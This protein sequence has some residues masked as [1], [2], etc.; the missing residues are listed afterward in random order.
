MP[1]E[2]VIIEGRNCWR[3]RRARRA[4]VLVDGAQ[5]FA[6][7][8][9]VVENA[10]KLV[11]ISG[12]D[13]DSRIALRRDDP[14]EREATLLGDFLNRKAAET[15]GLHIYIL[16][17]D[18]AMIY[19]LERETPPVFNLG[20]RHHR[21]IHFFMDSRHPFGASHHQKIVAIDD[22]IAFSGGFDLTKRR[23]DTTDHHTHDP[24]RLDIS[25]QGYRPLHDTMMLVDY[26]AAR[27][28]C[29]LFRNRWEKAT[30]KRIRN[31]IPSMSV[32]DPW[33]D[34][35]VP[36][37][38]DVDV[39]IARTVPAFKGEE[40]IREVEALYRDTMSS[41]RD[42]IYIEN[43][44]LTSS[45]ISEFLTLQLRKEHGPEIVILLPLTSSGWLAEAG[46]DALRA[47]VLNKLHSAD[48][49][50]R[51][52]V[53]Y[54][55]TL[56]TGEQPIFVHAKLMIVDDRVLR[57][58]SSNLS[59]RSMGF[60]TECD[61]AIEADGHRVE[62]AIA[63]VKQTLLSEHLGV[64]QEECSECL[65]A[66]RSLIKTI[67]SL[68]GRKRTL[69]P[70][71]YPM[72]DSDWFTSGLGIRI[73]D[74]EKPVNPDRFIAD[75]LPQETGKTKA[76]YLIESF[77]V[78]V[79]LAML[80]ALGLWASFWDP[81]AIQQ[82]EQWEQQLQT[83][84]FTPLI[85]MGIYMVGGILAFPLTILVIVTV[86]LFDPLIG[87]LYALLGSLLNAAVSYSIGYKLGRNTVRNLVGIRINRLSR[88]LARQGIATIAMLRN[89]PIASYTL[90]NIVAGASRVNLSD[91]LIGTAIGITP[92]IAAII[93]VAHCI[94]SFVRNPQP[95]MFV[96][97]FLLTEGF[98]VAAIWFHRRFIQSQ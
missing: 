76:L 12:W 37:F 72:P 9:D 46:M 95:V 48:Q 4:A 19:A 31:L 98:I 34:T 84:R 6:A 61:L 53:Y 69:K 60:D 20:W 30:G 90:V 59:N 81:N 38:T 64:S 5:Y 75:I 87:L 78:F 51:L 80:T 25:P 58:G 67:E 7:V 8:A 29:E 45:L 83:S 71:D 65:A 18:F 15:P 63:T 54:P 2:P 13:F 88:R 85:V 66:H 73:L 28:L 33:P 50:N 70:L 14:R 36:H 89:L 24:R 91:Y 57:I 49:Y 42:S 23:W 41:A 39:A 32:L 40:E 79:V 82:L 44:Y 10:R 11:L 22:Q 96:L 86:F 92:G 52:R 3:K 26:E 55:V 21:R 97:L 16:I 35:V 68:Q 27:S 74:P 93:L 56:E 1:Q 47:L 17:W 77:S 62:A 43:Q 94:K